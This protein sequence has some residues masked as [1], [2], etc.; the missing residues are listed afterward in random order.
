M[1]SFQS[2]HTQGL[3]IWTVDDN[4]MPYDLNEPVLFRVVGEEW[5]DQTPTDPIDKPGVG[6]EDAP[7]PPKEVP[8]S[9][10]GSMKDAGL[11]PCLWWE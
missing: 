5:H 10:R 4:Q 6:D 8:Y 3:W 11:G 9:I 1:H 7:P 2:D